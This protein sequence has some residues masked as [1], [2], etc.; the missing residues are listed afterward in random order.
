MEECPRL[1]GRFS[2]GRLPRFQWVNVTLRAAQHHS[3]NSTQG[4]KKKVYEAGRKIWWLGSERIVGEG[5]DIDVIKI[6][7]KLK[8]Y[9]YVY[10]IN[11]WMHGWMD[12]YI[13]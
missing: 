10:Q 8:L 5:L 4:L 3:T 2:S 13:L 9:A 12:E 7:M 6:C 11:I 1:L